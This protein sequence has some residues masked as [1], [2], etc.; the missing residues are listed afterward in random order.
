V[1]IEPE[2]RPFGKLKERLRSYAE[3]THKIRAGHP[4]MLKVQPLIFFGL[5]TPWL[6]DVPNVDRTLEAQLESAKKGLLGFGIAGDVL[7]AEVREIF[8][9]DKHLR[10]CCGHPLAL[11]YFLD[12][13]FIARAADFISENHPEL[14]DDQFTSFENYVY[15]QGA[16]TRLLYSHLFN[17]D[18]PIDEIDLGS[19]KIR[20]LEPDKITTLLGEPKLPGARSFLQP[21]DVGPFFVL[22]QETGAIENEGDWFFSRH[23]IA[24]DLARVFQFGMKGVVQLDYSVPFYSPDW[25]N[26]LR[27]YGMFFIG[28]PRK[29]PYARG[30]RPFTAKEDDLLRIRRLVAAY[31]SQKVINLVKDET[32]NFRQASLR[33]G[34][35]FEHSMTYERPTERLI[36][37][38]IAIEALF[39]P[40]DSH[41][42]KF[43]ISQTAS[44]LL[45]KNPA[46]RQ[47]IYQSIRDLYDRRSELMHGTYSVKKVNEGSYVTHEEIDDWSAIIQEGILRFFALFLRG[48]RTK[49]DLERL[50]NDLL[51]SALDPQI[52]EAI[53]ERSDIEI[54]LTDF[55]EG[56]LF[57]PPS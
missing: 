24:T 56:R 57:G 32:S 28:N 46:E 51:M 30:K 54:L 7:A 45:G 3:L 18:S 25:V 55:E 8:A 34:D 49:T 9:K 26:G 41:E 2:I 43:R 15:G 23:A 14:V 13:E 1:S 44:Q 31:M 50:R 4:A 6:S 20:K 37:L 36:A 40:G 19:I 33:A 42:Y 22:Q 29:M 11:A 10:E 17:F 38:S 52:A 35:Y 48:A 39:S 16:F 27:R 47:R 12:K 53:R 5:V 21:P